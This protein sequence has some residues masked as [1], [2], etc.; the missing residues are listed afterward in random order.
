MG[1]R[2][3][4]R[5]LERRKNINTEYKED[6]EIAAATMDA[7]MTKYLGG[8]ESHTHLVKGLDLA[9]LQKVCMHPNAMCTCVVM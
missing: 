2:Y 6:D 7:E 1:C 3:R 4:D 5:A 8:D 9:L